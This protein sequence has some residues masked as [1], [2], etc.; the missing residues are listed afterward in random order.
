LVDIILGLQWGD[1]GKGKIVDLMSGNYSI[2]ARFQGGPNAGH[3]I[4][5]GDKKF[6]L[7]QVP[8]G[9]T[10]PET[11]NVIGNGVVLDPLVLQKEIN[12][13]QD[14]GI[15]VTSRLLV[16]TKTNL[17]T[18]YHALLD[19]LRENEQ[20]EKKIGSTLKGIGPAYQD[21]I[22]RFGIR[23]GDCT[24]K[25]FD[26]AYKNLK[27]RFS[28]ILA[29]YG[30]DGN[31]DDSEWLQSIEL[32]R[33]MKITET[34]EFLNEA[35]KDNKKILAE[36]AQ[37]TLLDIDFGTYP[38]VT[39]SNTISASACTGLGI[40]PKHI[41]KVYGVFKAYCTRVGGGP[42][43]TELLD[44][45]GQFIRDRGFEY[46]SVTKRPRRCGWMDLPALKY[47][48]MLNGVDELIMM[49]IDVLNELENISVC[50]KYLNQND[51]E[52][53]FSAVCGTEGV[54]P[55][56]KEMKGWGGGLAEAKNYD[57]LPVEA[58]DYIVFMQKECDTRISVVSTGPERNETLFL[59]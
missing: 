38:Y 37:G 51:E 7:R 57:D 27:D 56:Y 33:K 40:A 49:K 15:E 18:P 2:V 5:I 30:H 10:R 42:F 3:T 54:H 8:S 44:S 32:L 20:G 12:S 36:G 47:S 19:S 13:L 28:S 11:L 46:G 31:V 1:E 52:I 6:I 55:E 22:G 34:E 4:I 23:A 39:S 41:K 48:I 58:K 17:I 24:H 45:T 16:S 14:A 9:I 53:S 35:I 59:A 50:T 25:G 29:F 43:P 26:T 21:K